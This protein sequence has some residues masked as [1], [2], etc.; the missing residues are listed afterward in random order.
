LTPRQAEILAAYE[1]LGSKKAVA[2]E[3]GLDSATVRR[4][5]DRAQLDPAIAD[6]MRAVGTD[7][8]PALAWAKVP[9]KD[10]E[11]GYSVL[12][13]PPPQD[14]AD[15][16]ARMIAQ[17]ADMPPAPRVAAPAHVNKGFLGIHLVADLHMG[18]TITKAEAGIEYNRQIAEER[19]RTGFAQCNAA[20]PPCEV[21]VVAY[22]GDTTHANDDKHRTPKSGHPLRVEGSHQSNIFGVEVVLSWQIDEALA[23]HESVVVVIKPGNHDPNTPAPLILAMRARYRDNPRVTVIDSE[24]PYFHIQMGRLFLCMHH[25]DGA[26]PSKRA[27]SI[28]HKFRREWGVSDFHWF[29]SADKHHAKADTFGGLHWRQVPSIISLEQHAHGEGYADTSGMYAA[30]F[31][32][33][34]GR[35]SETEIRF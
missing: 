7:M 22:N 33:A 27:M 16:L 10:G 6:S 29:F 2:R 26:S 8:I 32:T 28:P 20:M 21:A 11:P 1:R 24:D 12:L 9:A 3:M 5:I 34:T 25:G 4:A 17:L 18:A 23:K 15:V 30:W 19:V 14:H 35:V 31:D 13:K